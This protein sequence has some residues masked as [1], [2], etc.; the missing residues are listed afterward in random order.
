MLIFLYGVIIKD[1][2]VTWSTSKTFM[3][4]FE[5]LVSNSGYTPGL[6]QVQ[7]LYPTFCISGRNW[8]ER[9]MKILTVWKGHPT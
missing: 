9:W 3:K 1:V 7:H 5:L 8:T 4:F 6:K 2:N